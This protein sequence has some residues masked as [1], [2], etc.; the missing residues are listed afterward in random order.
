MNTRGNAGRQGVPPPQHNL[1]D[2]TEKAV[3]ALRGQT[4]GQLRWL[5]AEPAGNAWR[6]E[7][8]GQAIDADIRTG[9]VAVAGGQEVRPAWRILTLHYLA[10]KQRPAETP[11]QITFAGIPDGIAYARVYEKRVIGRLCA[12]AGR[13]REMLEAAAAL[14]AATCA[15]GGDA[16]FDITV[17]PR[18]RVRLVW[19]AADDEFD[20]SATLLLPGNIESFFCAD[21]I[22]VLS[23]CL[24]SRMS[25]GSF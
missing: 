11:P 18:V 12:T 24:V 14:V 9:R 2:A 5:G 22:V 16:A 21:D 1:R 4:P 25:G 8:L 6:I 19:Y 17:F 7:V 15:E 13:S 20:S 3:E 10:V 23:E